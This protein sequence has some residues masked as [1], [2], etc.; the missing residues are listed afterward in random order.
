MG[1]KG[2]V[3]VDGGGY[4]RFSREMLEFP[5]ARERKGA[6]GT[7]TRPLGSFPTC[8]Y[9]SRARKCMSISGSDER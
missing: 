7:A 5:E 4:G 3:D 1:G 2:D 6:K 8:R 9:S